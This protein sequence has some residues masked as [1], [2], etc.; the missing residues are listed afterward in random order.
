MSRYILSC[1]ASDRDTKDENSGPLCQVFDEI[2]M[3]PAGSSLQSSIMNNFHQTYVSDDY[4]Q[5]L[6]NKVLTDQFICILFFLTWG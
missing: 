2:S 5:L 6:G 3:K 1:I 4:N